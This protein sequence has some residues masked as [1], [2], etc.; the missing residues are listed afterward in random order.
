M[1]REEV[2]ELFRMLVEHRSAGDHQAIDPLFRR[3]SHCGFK[4]RRTV[5]FE[6]EQLHLERATA[7]TDLGR[8]KAPT[9]ASHRKATRDAA[10]AA[11]LN[12]SNWF[13]PISS[14]AVVRPVM[15]PRGRAKLLTNPAATGSRDEATITMGIVVVAS[16]A[17]L[18][19]A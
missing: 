17:A 9:V 10:G 8:L 4:I 2:G 7:S 6:R 19:D 1:L 5:Y 14:G 3:S 13:P 11:S 12:H 18:S 16:R 15:L